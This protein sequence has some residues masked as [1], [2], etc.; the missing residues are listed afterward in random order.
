MAQP[1]LLLPSAPSR[2]APGCD[3][4][5]GTYHLQQSRFGWHV[6]RTVGL[7]RWYALTAGGGAWRSWSTKADAQAW[8][9]GQGDQLSDH[10]WWGI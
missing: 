9:D 7:T 1:L 10:P 3:L 8:I 6:V 4:P 5:V 2:V